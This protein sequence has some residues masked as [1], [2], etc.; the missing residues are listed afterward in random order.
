MSWD[1]LR[2]VLA[3]ARAGTMTAAAQA[4]GV[5]HTTVSR[6]V[7]AIEEDIGTRVF[8]QTPDGFVPTP[9]GRRLV[10]AAAA[11]EARVTEVDRAV[12]GRDER[13]SGPLRVATVDS[14]VSWFPEVFFGFA[15]ANPEVALSVA[16]GTRFADLSRRQADVALRLTN[17]PAEH[18]FGRKVG[19]L[20]YGIYAHRS[21][22]ERNQSLQELPWI[23][24]SPD[25]RARLTERWMAANVPNAPIALQVDCTRAFELAISRGLGVQFM[26]HVFARRTPELV[27][28]EPAPEEFT[29]DLWLLAHPD[30]REVARVRA[31]MSHAAEVMAG[32]AD[33]LRPPQAG[34]AIS[35]DVAR[36][37]RTHLAA[38]PREL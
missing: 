6:R 2:F 11:I 32:L 7:R 34:S 5:T 24:W 29:T 38:Q 19:Q 13:L 25:A 17:S 8:D 31:F 15:E 21:L 10:E 4:L 3:L 22:A 35:E 1:D 20:E 23:Q 12:R 14:F 16:T 33:S 30:L 36:S 18:L 9:A 27:L 28:L 37:A 26:P